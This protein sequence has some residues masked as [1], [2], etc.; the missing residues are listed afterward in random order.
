M[1]RNETSDPAQ[2]LRCSPE[3]REQYHRAEH[4]QCEQRWRRAVRF[5]QIRGRLILHD[6]E[7]R[8]DMDLLTAQS[9]NQR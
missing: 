9:L 5:S 1:L 6:Q 3:V 8:E 4:D 7:K 2:L